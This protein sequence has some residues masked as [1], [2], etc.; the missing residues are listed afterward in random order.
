ME[1]AVH[2]PCRKSEQLTHPT[3]GE[4]V[5]VRSSYAVIGRSDTH[6]TV[7]YTGAFTDVGSTTALI[8]ERPDTG[9][10]SCHPEP[11]RSAAS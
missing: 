4:T 6:F 5:T 10:G 2:M 7:P 11:T 8:D 3:V 1:A 9:Y